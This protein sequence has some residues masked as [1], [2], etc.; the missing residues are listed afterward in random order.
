M[1][2]PARRCLGWS[3]LLPHV[4]MEDSFGKDDQRPRQGSS[5]R[6]AGRKQPAAL[7]CTKSPVSQAPKSSAESHAC[8]T[9]WPKAQF[10]YLWKGSLNCGS[11]GGVSSSENEAH[12]DL[13]ASTCLLRAPQGLQEGQEGIFP[14]TQP[15]K[16]NTLEGRH[17]MLTAISRP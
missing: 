4:K 1:K 7:W 2:A 10:C 8:D 13:L 11:G 15:L 17:R 16:E 9:G 12:G 14:S 6:R 5:G 3:L